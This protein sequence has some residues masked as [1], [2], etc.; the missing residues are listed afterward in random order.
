MNWKNPTNQNKD[1]SSTSSNQTPRI[2]SGIDD[3]ERHHG[4]DGSEVQQGRSKAQLYAE[5]RQSELVSEIFLTKWNIFQTL[6]QSG[7]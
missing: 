4:G 5:V 1:Q 6:I 2:I 7:T 3:D